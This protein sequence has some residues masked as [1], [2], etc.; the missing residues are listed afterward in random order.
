MGHLVFMGINPLS[1]WGL[2]SCI[3]TL[4]CFGRAHV[5]LRSAMWLKNKLNLRGY[6]LCDLKSFYFIPPLMHEYW[7]KRLEFLNQ[8]GKMI[9]P[10]PAGFYCLVVQKREIIDNSILYQPFKTR[11]LSDLPL[12]ASGGMA[13]GCR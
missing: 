4:P 8:M 5:K 13:A 3:K 12:S 7:I 2:S 6:Q 9:W 10:F 1:F 11:R